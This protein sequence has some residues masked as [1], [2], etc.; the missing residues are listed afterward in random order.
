MKYLLRE[1][2]WVFND[3]TYDND[4][5][6]HTLEIF[7]SKVEAEKRKIELEYEYFLNK[8]DF[9]HRYESYGDYKRNFR[10][11][12]QKVTTFLVD[13]FDLNPTIRLI[14]HYGYCA[15]MF[16]RELSQEDV[17]KILDV[18]NIEF[19]SIVQREETTPLQYEAK[20]N[21]FYYEGRE[22]YLWDYNGNKK[23][24]FDSK[25]EAIKRFIEKEY[26]FYHFTYN[27]NPKLTGSLSQISDLPELLKSLIAANSHIDYDNETLVI[28]REIDYKSIQELNE[29]L[30]EPIII[31][32]EFQTKITDEKFE[33]N[34]T[35]I[36][37]QNK[38]EKNIIYEQAFKN[39]ENPEFKLSKEYLINYSFRL[40]MDNR[41]FNYRQII[42]NYLTKN[43][44]EELSEKYGYLYI[45]ETMVQFY[46]VIKSL[47]HVENEYILEGCFGYEANQIIDV[48]KTAY[49]CSGDL[50]KAFDDS[51]K[52]WLELYGKEYINQI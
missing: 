27:K 47:K 26:H 6:Y 24:K 5:K 32:E 46:G 7:E 28:D 36:K 14:G 1:I 49:G 8:I 39:T 17:Q 21:P 42:E 35:S 2:G 50:E 44:Q 30:K 12:K 13:E 25:S 16:L 51:F 11:F 23:L 48:W 4:G 52:N 45:G 43:H 15:S 19:I 18:M 33:N 31:F 40:S 20:L 41:F 34:L 29:L 22:E 10:D 3:S 37:N 38:G 9:I